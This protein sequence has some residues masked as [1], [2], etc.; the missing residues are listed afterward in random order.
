[1]SREATTG[2]P[3]LKAERSPLMPTTPSRRSG[4]HKCVVVPANRWGLRSCPFLVQYTRHS[5]EGPTVQTGLQASASPCHPL[6]GTPGWVCAGVSWHTGSQGLLARCGRSLSSSLA[7]LMG[8]STHSSSAC[9]S[10]WSLPAGPLP[11][12]PRL[13]LFVIS[14]LLDSNLKAWAMSHAVLFNFVS[15]A[16]RRPTTGA[17]LSPWI[18]APGAAVYQVEARTGSSERLPVPSQWGRPSGYLALARD[19]FVTLHPVWKVNYSRWAG[20]G[21]EAAGG[22][23]PARHSLPHTLTAGSWSG[24]PLGAPLS[25]S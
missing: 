22:P 17:G 4:K 16:H 23:R 25:G 9:G 24:R 3:G 10:G 19:L 15:P 7:R 21:G 6:L 12:A 2:Q 8:K 20:H 18:L 14:A 1:M 13:W 11:G 5:M